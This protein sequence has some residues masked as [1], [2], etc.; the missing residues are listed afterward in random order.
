MNLRDDDDVISSIFFLS[1]VI[2]INKGRDEHML[3]EKHWESF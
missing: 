3:Q 2:A 1:F